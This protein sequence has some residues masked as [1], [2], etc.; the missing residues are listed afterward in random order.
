MKNKRAGKAVAV[1]GEGG[2]AEET[3]HENMHVLPVVKR[4]RVLVGYKCQF[5]EAK[6]RNS[7]I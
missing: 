2:E 7:E 6:P 5:A 1:V 4:V 3:R